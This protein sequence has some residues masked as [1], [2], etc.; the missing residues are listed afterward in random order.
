M[1][2]REL[3]PLVV[4]VLNCAMLA[5]TGSLFSPHLGSARRLFEA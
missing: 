1:E 2:L 4:M 5:G 3:K